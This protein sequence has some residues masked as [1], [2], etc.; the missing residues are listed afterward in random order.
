MSRIV[1]LHGVP[2]K[3][4]SERDVV[5]FEVLREEYHQASTSMNARVSRAPTPGPT[6]MSI[7]HLLDLSSAPSLRVFIRCLDRQ[8]KDLLPLNNI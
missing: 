8:A 2:K 4:V 1:C 5:Y 7:L 3:I 6:S